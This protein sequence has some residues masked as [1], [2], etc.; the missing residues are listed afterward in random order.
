[1]NGEMI[2]TIILVMWLFLNIMLALYIGVRVDENV[3][4]RTSVMIAIK[5][6]VQELFSDK[7]WFGIILSGII[8]II[9]IPALLFMFLM[10]VFYWLIV[11]VMIIWSLGARKKNKS[12]P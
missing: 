1:M 4:A 9:V 8:L 6:F 10:Q 7:N 3:D 11:L 2:L 12:I 5:N